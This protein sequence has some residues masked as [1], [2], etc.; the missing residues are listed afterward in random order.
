MKIH[1]SLN[2]KNLDKS[3]AFYKRMFGKEP[4]KFIKAN[5]ISNSI[6]KRRKKENN[7]KTKGGYAKFDLDKP[8]LNLALNEVGFKSG[9]SL[10][11]LGLQ[12]ETTDDVLDFRRR[13]EKEGL[14]TIDEM[15]VNCCYAKQDKTWV[16]D[17]DGN[18]W[19]AFVVLENSDNSVEA[20]C[21]VSQCC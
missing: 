1:I 21:Y 10:S 9:G 12:L 15:S 5:N 7:E 2:V 16:H 8:P 11:H 20:E 19:E 17:P 14:F 18:K 13:W 6:A 4:L 3:V